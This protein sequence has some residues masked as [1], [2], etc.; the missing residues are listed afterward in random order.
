MAQVKERIKIITPEFRVS[1]PAV[2]EARKVNQND[3]N[4][5]PKFSV[6][7][8]F[9]TAESEAS[10]KLGEKVVK[11]DEIKEAVRKVLFNKFGEA[12]RQEVEKRKGDGTP[13]IRLPFKDGNAPEKRDKDGF[14][15]GVIYCSATSLQRPGLID[16]QKKEI[17]NA[18]E[19]YGGCYA[20]AELNPFFYSV[21]GN[22]GV[23]LGL[24]N[25]QKIRDGEPFSGKSKAEDAFDAIEAPEGAAP[26]GAANNGD[27]MGL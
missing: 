1:F 11:I 7:M 13:L 4:E 21:L 20:R 19:F 2:F 25:L 17:L 5:K 12:W 15:P 9:R 22:Q 23:S 26:A 8:L 14:G 24:Q 18:S 10:K 3:P 27:P 6:M 16:A